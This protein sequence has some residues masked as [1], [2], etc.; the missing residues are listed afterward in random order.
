VIVAAELVDDPYPFYEQLRHRSP[1]WRVP[2]TDAFFVSSW[3]L[4][5]EAAARAGDF[6][7]HFRHTLFTKKDGT[8]GVVDNGEGGA[9]D[10]FAGADPP[11]HTAHRQV[12]FPELVQARMDRLE[13]EVATLAGELLDDMLERGC[14]DAAA[15][16]A[17]VLPLRIMAERVIGFHAPDLARTQRWVFG[18]AR[19]MGGRLRLDELDEVGAEVAGMWPWVAEQLDH[20]LATPASSCR[21]VLGAAATGVRDGV[22]TSDEAAFTLMVLLGAG[23]ETTTSL[24]GNAVRVLAERPLL[25]EQ[26][27]AEPALV[28]AFVE[29][30]LRFESPFRFHPRTARGPVELG[31]VEIPDRAMVALLWGAANR[32]P[33]VFERPDEIV[34]GRANA[35]QQVAFGRGIHHCV[36]APLAR[37]ESRVVLTMLLERTRRFALDPNDPPRWVDSLWI[38]RHERVP[39]RVDPV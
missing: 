6:S 4:V 15:D 35:R 26:L 25:Q 21:D 39:M 23:G 12:F 9:P 31:G 7:N 27:R 33:S 19:F 34:L 13:P 11:D 20:A 16:L 18:G 22:L 36:G 30:V 38:R 1:V 24:I 5:T 32:D 3:E 17:D 10:V 2:G 28:P 29:E 8:L 14:A 37:L